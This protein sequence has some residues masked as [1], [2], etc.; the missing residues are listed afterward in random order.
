MNTVQERPMTVAWPPIIYATAAILAIVLGLIVPLP[1]MPR[2]LSDFAFAAGIIVIVGAIWIDIAALQ[3]MLRAGTP[4]LP[5][6]RAEHLVTGGPFAFTRNP[7][8]LGNTMLMLGAGLVFGLLWFLPAA[9]I[10]AFLTQRIAIEAEEK[11]LES[12]FGRAYRDYR[13][14]VRRWI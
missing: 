1:W 6:R 5:T 8:Y 14:K 9:V 4:Y 13:K 3:A 11:H 7:I 2:P 10:A 12:R